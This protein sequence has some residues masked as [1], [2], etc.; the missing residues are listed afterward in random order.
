MYFQKGKKTIVGRY[1]RNVN[2]L[3][4]REGWIGRIVD[5]DETYILVKYNGQTE[6][7][8]SL[9]N[10]RRFPYTLQLYLKER[11]QKLQLLKKSWHE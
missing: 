2:D 7:T 8:G 6:I 10:S 9:I 3:S 5:E 1:V 11:K 4:N